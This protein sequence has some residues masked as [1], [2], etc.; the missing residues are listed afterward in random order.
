[1][2]RVLMENLIGPFARRVGTLVG[3]TLAASGYL[4]GET[5]S[6]LPEAA[7]IVS[8]VGVDLLSSWFN[9]RQGMRP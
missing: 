1:M 7:F 9:R 8:G 5:A 4:Y 6:L 3:G 2:N